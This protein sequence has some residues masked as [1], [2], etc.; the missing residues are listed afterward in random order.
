MSHVRNQLR[1]HLP[2]T[3]CFG[4]GPT[5]AKLSSGVAHKKDQGRTPGGRAGPSNARAALHCAGQPRPP[6][7]RVD[8]HLAR[9]ALNAAEFSQITARSVTSPRFLRNNAFSSKNGVPKKK[10]AR[11]GDFRRSS[12]PGTIFNRSKL[13]PSYGTQIGIRTRAERDMDHSNLD[14]LRTSCLT[15][16]NPH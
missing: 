11:G 5:A 16:T 6:R 3:S 13:Q 4:I 9:R 2:L 15:K 14:V 1:C 7:Q 10:L 12:S 8:Q